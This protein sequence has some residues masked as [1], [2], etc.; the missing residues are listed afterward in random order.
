M[1]HLPSEHARRVRADR[2]SLRPVA[3]ATA[4]AVIALLMWA[5]PSPAEVVGSGPVAAL[6][7]SEKLG[8]D[9]VLASIGWRWRFAPGQRLRRWAAAAATDLS[10][11]VE[12][13]AAA[14]AGDKDSVEVQVVPL[15][16]LEP[17]ATIDRAWSP[18][19]EAGV[20]VIYTALEGLRLGSN[21][22]FSDNVGV[23]IALRTGEDGRRFSRIL[24][25]YRFRHISHA[26]IF[27]SPNSGMNTHYLTVTLE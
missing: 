12:P 27:G 11:A 13:M 17:N 6:G 21:L 22:L 16:H 2:P 19:L 23:G 5:P 10:F 18:Y 4:G 1:P 9:M 26:G 14:I 15:V 25:G 8:N 3:V 20:G 7:F 24:L